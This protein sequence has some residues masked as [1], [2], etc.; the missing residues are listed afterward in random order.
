[1]SDPSL[2]L[3]GALVALLKAD[4]GV[5]TAARVYD[6]PPASPT[7]PYVVVGDD[8]VIGDDVDCAQMSEVFARIHVW[9]R[10]VGFPET[11]TIA[12]AI[13]T[14]IR[15]ATFTLT[16][17]TVNEVKFVQAPSL[18]DPDGLSRHIPLEFQFLIQH[19]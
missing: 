14:R 13:R 2:L 4:G 12:A 10:G 19:D 8:Q 18:R 1:M 7:F 11:K 9:S 17:F 16:G 15:G 3:Q 5:G 6:E